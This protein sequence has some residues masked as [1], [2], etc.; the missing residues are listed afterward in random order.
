MSLVVIF[1]EAHPSERVLSVLTSTHEPPY[2]GRTDVLFDP[3][4]SGLI[5]PQLYWRHDT[6]VIRDMNVAEK[7]GLDAEIEAQRIIDTRGFAN[8]EM[9]ALS[10]EGVRLRAVADMLLRELNILRTWD[11]DF[12]VATAASTNLNNF[13][14]GVAGLPSLSDRTMAQAKASYQNLINAG[15]ADT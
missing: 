8:E 15:D 9:L 3:D 5:E 2:E 11:R 10:G 12:Q 6:G 13:K 7:A 14:S 1:D 4:L